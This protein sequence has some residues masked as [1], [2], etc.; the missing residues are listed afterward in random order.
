L[1]K[2]FTY[3]RLIVVWASMS[4][5]DFAGCLALMVPFADC[6]IFTRPDKNRSA[7]VEQLKACVAAQHTKTVLAYEN[8][9][10]AVR[11]AMQHASPD[12]LICVAGSL[13]LVGYARL[14]LCGE[15]VNG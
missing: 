6:L 7:T 12:D 11:A 3:Q 10:D 9:N 13:Y 1:Q 5:K 14:F 8:V 2:Q 4:D 15:I